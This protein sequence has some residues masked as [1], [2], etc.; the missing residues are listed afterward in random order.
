MIGKISELLKIGDALF[1]KHGVFDAVLGVD[2]RL[3]LDSRLLRKT[4]IP[5]F[6]KSKERITAYFGDVVTLLTAS[7][8]SEDRA[9][10]EARKRLIF[11]ETTG[12]SIGYGVHSSDGS[13][14]GPVLGLK[15]LKSAQEVIEMGIRDPEIFELI[16]LFEEGFGADRLSD[17]IIS[18]IREDLFSYSQRVTA[19]LNIPDSGTILVKYHGSEYKMVRNPI[20]T[21]KPLVFIPESLLSDLP[22]ASTFDGIDYVVR[23]NRELREDINKMIGSSIKQT[24]KKQLK[25]IIFKDAKNINLLLQHYHNASP[26]PYDLKED[27]ASQVNWYIAGKIF[28]DRFPVSMPANP[29]DLNALNEIVNKI[30]E[31]FKKNIELNGANELLWTGKKYHKK[32]RPERYS[33]LLFFS[34]ADAYCKANNVD[35]NREPN[36]GSG[37]V[38]F[39][40]SHG[41]EARV[42]VELKLSSNK[43][44][45]HGYEKQLPTYQ[46]S[47][48]AHRSVYVILQVTETAKSVETVLELQK[49][50]RNKGEKAPDIILIDA[51]LKPSASKR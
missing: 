38:D 20:N 6:R 42:L 2:T 16:G 27:P 44:L 22:V 41:Y 36:S 19:E 4:Q 15:L 46:E 49:E 14:V 17:M 39:K 9:W 30:I 34:T 25:E 37:P 29:T 51:R 10:M 35:I 43:S 18:I 8:T 33:Q 24:S 48:S 40:L 32:V 12:V 45:V 7:K 23:V 13:A 26:D 31:Q 21:R 3:F 47:E 11:R 1:K 5:E 50:A 28:A